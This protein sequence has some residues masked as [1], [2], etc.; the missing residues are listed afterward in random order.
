MVTSPVLQRHPDDS[1]AL[2]APLKVS[3]RTRRVLLA[4][5]DAIMPTSPRSETTLEDVTRHAL[6]SLQYMPR[7]SALLFLVG[8]RLLNWA[9]LWRLR[10]LRPLTRMS[11]GQARRHLV[12][13]TQSRWL[14]V[15]L[16]M[17]GPLGLFMSNYFDQD[18]AHRAIGYDPVPFVE[19]RIELRR[20]WV[21]GDE[22][23]T[24]DEIHHLRVAPP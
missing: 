3:P 17:Y 9:P 21:E 5:A 23:T 18:Y 2:A 16:S 4:L 24:D 15:R 12:A 11:R 6:V 20:K 7:S 14:P 19:E 22:P 10:G 13:V 1:W 8:M